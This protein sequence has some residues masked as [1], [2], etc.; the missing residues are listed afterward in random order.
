[1]GAT[2]SHTSDI[3]V[4]VCVDGSYC[5]GN[6]NTACCDRQQGYWL[7][8]GKVFAY[9]DAPFLGSAASS[10]SVSASPS[11]TSSSGSAATSS[12]SSTTGSG[13]TAGANIKAATSS[14]DSAKT[15]GLGVGL[16]LGIPLIMLAG[17]TFWILSSRRR[18]AAQTPIGAYPSY[19]GEHMD[20]KMYPQGPPPVEI[21]PGPPKEL[22]SAVMSVPDSPKTNSV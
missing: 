1:V 19:Y 11:A 6:N 9:K 15:V 7:I 8:N 10:S 22:E 14:K 21:G 17:V 12:A 20:A 2:D 13:S 16:G 4:S 3:N 18:K 5:C